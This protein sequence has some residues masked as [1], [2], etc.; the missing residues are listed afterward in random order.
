MQLQ[1]YL[2]TRGAQFGEDSV[3]VY[4]RNYLLANISSI[5]GP[6]IAAGLCEVRFLGRRG[7]MV[8]GAIGTAVFFF[9]YTQVRSNAQNVGFNCAIR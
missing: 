6:I 4:W 3:S 7:T 2:A 9:A 8:V 5:V 1:T